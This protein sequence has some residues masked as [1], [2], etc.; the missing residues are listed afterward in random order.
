MYLPSLKKLALREGPNTLPLVRKLEVPRLE[1]II[2]E[3]ILEDSEA[4]IETLVSHA[5]ENLRKISLKMAHLSASTFREI[6]HHSPNLTSL[7]LM[8]CSNQPSPKLQ[9][10]DELLNQLASPDGPSLCPGLE[11]IDCDFEAEF[12]YQGF[13]DFVKRK[14]SGAD[15]QL[16]KLKEIFIHPVSE[17]DQKTGRMDY[18]FMYSDMKPF[19]DDGLSFRESI[20]YEHNSSIPSVMF[21][22]SEG[23][24]PYDNDE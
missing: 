22:A 12:T 23:W 19:V 5:N 24:R 11:K 15:G 7:A 9:F 4:V 14:Q 1:E 6:L 21:S 10:D 18:R 2:F 20:N 17:R 13:L 16:A 8:Q 3:S